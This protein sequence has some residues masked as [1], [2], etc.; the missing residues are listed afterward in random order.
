MMTAASGS[1]FDVLLG[2]SNCNRQ[3]WDISIAESDEFVIAPTLGSLIPGWLLIIPRKWQLN[4][5]DV[6]IS[7]MPVDEILT[8]WVRRLE[9][10]NEDWLW[11]EH[12][13]AV[14]GTSVGCGVDHAHL[15]LLVE[16]AFSLS[17]FASEVKHATVTE[18]RE[19]E[20]SCAYRTLRRDGPYYAFGDATESYVAEG[21]DLGSQFFRRV[22]AGLLGQS[23]QWDYKE[24]WGTDNVVATL[25]RFQDNRV[26]AE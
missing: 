21:A 17:D 4:F 10:P 25:Q 9:V 15:H 26:A 22:V 14:P 3:P 13:P 1:R 20:T 16:P 19:V 18:W 7:G 8:S 5:R 11:F 12:G 2:N 23:S 24:Y 6:Q